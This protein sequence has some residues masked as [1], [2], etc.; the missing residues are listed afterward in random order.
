MKMA[1]TTDRTRTARPDINAATERVRD[2]NERFAE[3]GRKVTTAY[4]D[5]VERYVLGLTKA[6]RRLGE[7]AQFEPV[8]QLFSAHANLTEDVVK[9][10]VSATRELITA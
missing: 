2:A 1:A 3:A 4:L 10:S 9:A 7:Q 6:E 5:G 8:G